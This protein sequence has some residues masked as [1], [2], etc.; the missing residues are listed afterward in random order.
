MPH[1]SKNKLS[2]RAYLEIYNQLFGILS[3][4]NRRKTKSVLDNLFTKTE[5]IML[6]KRL[7]IILMSAHG[8][9][10]YKI[11]ETLKVSPSTVERIGLKVERGEYNSLL[12][13]L[14]T[15]GQYNFWSIIEKIVFPLPARVGENRWR[16]LDSH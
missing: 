11:Y 6:A 12:R 1:I 9:S 5:R 8:E 7:A 13:Y 3:V 10:S 4:G 16:H 15:K 2:E 14:K